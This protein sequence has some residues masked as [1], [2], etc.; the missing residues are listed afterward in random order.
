[1]LTH[2]GERPHQCH[3]CP[4]RFTQ[5]SH[6]Q[7]HI[8][9]HTGEKPYVCN[10]C[11]KGFAING[12]LTVHRRMHTGDMPYVCLVCKRGFYDSS[13]LARHKKKSHLEEVQGKKKRRALEMEIDAATIVICE[14]LEDA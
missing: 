1:M 14:S 3:Q 4:S 11:G 5:L 7:S 10:Y 6:L 13:S 8:R 12:N 2:S 9:T